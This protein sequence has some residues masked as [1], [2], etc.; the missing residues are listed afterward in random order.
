MNKIII[1]FSGGLDSTVLLYKYINKGYDV[2]PITFYYGQKHHKEID[3][4]SSICLK[5]GLKH[6]I[7]NLQSLQRFLSSG[8]TSNDITIPDGHYEDETMKLTVVPNR[9]SILLNIAAAYAESNKINKIAIGVHAGD[10]AIYPDCRKE[11]IDKINELFLTSMYNP[12]TVEAPFLNLTKTDIVKLGASL[13][14]PFED[15][16]SCYKG[17]IYHCGKCGTCT[18]RIEAFKMANIKDKVMK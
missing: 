12:V 10:H 3:C 17:E 11:F 9:N 6:S 1:V 2:K 16:W 7:I 5:L 8:L 13:K 14:V 15:T 4:A 18:E